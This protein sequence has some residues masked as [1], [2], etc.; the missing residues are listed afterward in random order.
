MTSTDLRAAVSELSQKLVGQRLQNIYDVTPKMFLLKFAGKGGQ[1]DFVMIEV[2]SRIHSTTFKFDKPKIPS[3]FTLRIRKHIRQWRLDSLRQLGSDRVVEFVFGT[4]D[5]AFRLIIE[6]Y[7]KGNLILSDHAYNIIALTRSHAT[8]EAKYAVRATYPTADIQLLRSTTRERVEEAFKEVEAN[9][10]SM[11]LKTAFTNCTE[12]GPALVEHCLL[13]AGLRPNFKKAGAAQAGRDALDILMSA[14]EKADMFF[15]EIPQTKGFLVRRLQKEEDPA[16]VTDASSPPI[17]P[18]A[19]QFEDFA[20]M[21]Y[22]QHQGEGLSIE[23]FDSFNAAC[24]YYFS[25]MDQGTIDQHNKKSE[26][27]AS[28]KLDRALNNHRRRISELAKEQSANQ[29]K[30]SL[31]ETNTEEVDTALEIIRSALG[32]AMDWNELS[33]VIKEQKRLGNPVASIIHELKLDKNMVSLLLTGED[34]EGEDVV[35]VVDIDIAL[36][37]HAN[38]RNYFQVKKKIQE[39]QSKTE[40]AEGKAMQSAARK[41]ENASKKKVFAP[42]KDLGVVRKVLWFEKFNWF[43]TSDNYMVLSGRDAQQ[44]ELLVKRYLKKGDI[45]L[46]GDMHGAATTIIKNPSGEGVSQDTLYQAGN[47]AVCRSSAWETN[48][49]ISAW[50]VFDHQV[51]KTAPTGEYLPTGSFMIRG[52]KNFLPPTKIQLGAA[53]LFRVHQENAARHKG[54]RTN[55]EFIGNHD[56]VSEV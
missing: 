1:K 19:T 10:G 36:S 29:Q 9:T 50:W 41:A 31:I 3:A 43:I 32:R 46:H 28:T 55:P 34:E 4:D 47:M 21:L 35:V 20:P 18:P 13:T 53:V 14:F 7:A 11:S 30:A 22:K 42:K 12:F 8:E 45:Y 15:K 26:K 54:E 33:R 49:V 38:A 39:K 23:T 48:L 52:K 51:S 25:A 6:F 5:K 37:A 40:A 44:N 56:D 24:D 2:G 17:R 27:V 16:A